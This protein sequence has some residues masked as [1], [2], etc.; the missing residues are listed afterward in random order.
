MLKTA[1]VRPINGTTTEDVLSQIV[2]QFAYLVDEIGHQLEV[3]DKKNK[4][5]D[6][7]LAAL[8]EGANEN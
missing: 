5:L 8:E 2:T 3:L 1:K 4:E 7:R 6:R